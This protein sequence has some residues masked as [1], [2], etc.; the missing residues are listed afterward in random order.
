MAKWSENREYREELAEVFRKAGMTLG[1]AEVTSFLTYG[2]AIVRRNKVVNLTA[3]T[4]PGDVFRK[5]FLDSAILWK[6]LD[7]KGVEVP[8]DLKVVDVG[9]G[10]GLPGIPLKIT[11]P[12]VS[13]C[14]VD[15]LQKRVD[16][17]EETVKT[18]ELQGVQ[19][20][21]GRSEDLAASSGGALREA[22]DLAVSRAVAALPLLSEYCLPFVK[23]GGL[24]IAYKAGNVEEEIK[25]AEHAWQVLGGML[26]SVISFELPGTGQSRSLLLIRKTKAC[27]SAYPRKAGKPEKKP[28]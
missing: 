16:F 11:R 17:L 24:F 18:L 22:F 14:L 7:E 25:T 3:V 13:L 8:E 19:C 28:L 26:E 2:E 4:E 12:G 21:H 27:P 6:A 5:H 1:D 9:T 23:P 10:A 20:I 15:A